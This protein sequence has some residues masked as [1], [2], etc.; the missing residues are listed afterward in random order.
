MEKP[1][2]SNASSQSF[3]KRV[4]ELERVSTRIE[5]KMERLGKIIANISRSLS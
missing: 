4:K 5:A 3:K 2:K 1:L